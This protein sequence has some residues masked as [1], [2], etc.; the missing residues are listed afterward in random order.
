MTYFTNEIATDTNSMVLGAIQI[1]IYIA[2]MALYTTK[3]VFW[4]INIFTRTTKMVL[5][6]IHIVT[7]TRK[8]LYFVPSKWSF[9]P[10][11]A[12]RQTQ[13]NF[14]C[15]TLFLQSRELMVTHSFSHFQTIIKE[16]L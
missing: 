7:C 6:S 16:N 2:N 4:T 15:Y 9:V 13:V 1:V 10:S 3:M 12:D 11:V 14:G 8:M 5:R